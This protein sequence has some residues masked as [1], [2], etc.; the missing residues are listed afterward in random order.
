MTIKAVVRFIVKEAYSQYFRIN[1]LKALKELV[2]LVLTH[3]ATCMIY[4]LQKS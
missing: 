1:A 4:I 2:L 3:V